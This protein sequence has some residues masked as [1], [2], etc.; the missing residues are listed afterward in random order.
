MKNNSHPLMAFEIPGT[1]Q[2]YGNTVLGN[3]R[4]GNIVPVPYAD[5]PWFFHAPG[6]I[7]AF[8]KNKR[9]VFNPEMD[10]IL[11]SRQTDL[12]HGS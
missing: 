4:T 9:F 3:K 2:S 6:L 11:A 12:G 5:N 8:R 10:T 1:E 7:F